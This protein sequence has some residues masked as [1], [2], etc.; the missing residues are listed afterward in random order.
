ML[1]ER[2]IELM[3]KLRQLPLSLR[4]CQRHPEAPQGRLRWGIVAASLALLQACSTPSASDEGP[5][6]VEGSPSVG[7]PQATNS[8]VSPTPDHTPGV[9]SQPMASVSSPGV[10]GPAV[11]S[12]GVISPPAAPPVNSDV[13]SPV[14]SPAPAPTGPSLPPAE[15]AD[16][17]EPVTVPDEDGS[18]LWLRYPL[19]SLPN[20]LEEYRSA[21]ANVVI[22]G[23]SDTLTAAARELELGLGGLTGTTVTMGAAQ[24]SGDVVIGTAG[25]AEVDAFGFTDE[26]T[27]LGPDGYLVRAVSSDAGVSTVV[28][29]NTDVGVLYGAFA[30]L[31]QLS[32]HVAVADLSF[33]DSPKIQHRILN[34]WD[35]LDGAVERGYAGKS[36]WDWNALPGTLSPRYEQY[37]RANASIGINGTVLTNVNATKG[38]NEAMWGAQRAEYFQKVKALADVFRP[39]GIRVYLTAPF[40][41]GGTS[42]PNDANTRQWWV[43]RL[44][45]LYTLIPDFGGL[46]IKASSEGEPGPS[47]GAT[48]AD[49]ANMLAAAVGDRGLVLWRAFV[50]GE[51]VAADRIRQA[52]DQFK[53]LDGQFAD[54]VFVQVKNG[55]LDFQPREPFHP[56]FGGMPN[57]KLAIELQVTKEYLGQDTHLAYVG[58]M[59]E[60]ILQSDT[61][62]NGEGSTVARV[63]DGTVHGSAV[64]AIAGVS[65]VGNDVNWTGSHFNQ[66]NWYAYG[67]M[68][69]NP[70]LKA[71]EVAAEWARQTLSNDPDLVEPVADLMMKSYSA[72]VNYMTPLGLVHIMGTDHHYGPAPWVANLSRAEWNPVYY[73]DADAQGIGFD[74]TSSG[75]N[76][77]EQ[78]HSLLQARFADRATVGNDLLLFF[79]H[80]AWDDVLDTG[81]TV[82]EELVHRYSQGVDDVQVIAEQWQN[83]AEGR[84]DQARLDEMTDFLQIQHWEARWWRDACLGYFAQQNGKEIPAG[85]APLLNPLSFYQGLS[86]PSNRDKPRCQQVYDVEASPAVLP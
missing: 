21:F 29:G 41:A 85:Y 32:M 64:T 3:S 50:Y 34:H 47:D 83:A 23:T 8:T 63:I 19:V 16:Y 84:I 33:S 72:L 6:T 76:A 1:T 11:S 13:P 73:H 28:A 49:G 77:I 44:D 9:D 52:Y 39:Y 26:L 51:N 31:R 2:T 40:S 57:T 46:L 24:G 10:D 45:E 80:V 20:R 36:L 66:A 38:N 7:S 12:P 82:W 37:A 30:L 48:H 18:K 22:A 62:A 54:N 67:R 43:D 70:D 68:A 60:D 42:N 25:S 15:A 58:A 59:Y 74:R 65:N 53:P 35:D 55:P 78:Y 5:S 27:A 14:G 86:C 69:W 75:S 17:P 79:H 61:Y 56:L 81:R 71:R 4:R